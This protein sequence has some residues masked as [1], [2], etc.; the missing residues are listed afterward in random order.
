VD[1]RLSIIDQSP[2]L[3]TPDPSSVNL[4]SLDI[5]TS[6]DELSPFGLTSND[7]FSP[8]GLTHEIVVSLDK[9]LF[10]ATLKNE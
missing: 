8:F 6:N 10:G 3:S 1:A 7:E 2:L 9:F 4:A 5:Q